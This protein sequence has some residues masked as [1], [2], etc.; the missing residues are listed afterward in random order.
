M[1]A[2]IRPGDCEATELKSAQRLPRDL[3]RW[4]NGKI[5]RRWDAPGILEA[6]QGFHRLKRYA[7]M[8]ALVTALRT[9]DRQLGFLTAEDRQV[10][11]PSLGP[12][13]NF[14]PARRGSPGHATL[15]S[16]VLITFAHQ[17]Q[18]SHLLELLEC[19]RLQE[20][21]MEHRET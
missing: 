13:P 19:A 3:K 4:R 9:R 5:M 8:R 1:G 18:A 10:A 2:R 12:P 21:Q 15:R 17:R 11:S 14:S 7:D 20:R 6:V 16:V